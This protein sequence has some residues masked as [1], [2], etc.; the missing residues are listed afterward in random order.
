MFSKGPPIEPLSRSYPFVEGI[1]VG[2][3]LAVLGF[4]VVALVLIIWAQ[5][6]WGG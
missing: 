4:C 1:T 3:S 5:R 2:S 6:K